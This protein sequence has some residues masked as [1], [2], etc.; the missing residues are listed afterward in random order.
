[1]R[2]T[3]RQLGLPS[4]SPP[5]RPRRR[6]W[7]H[8]DALRWFVNR[9]SRGWTSFARAFSCCGLDSW[10]GAACRYRGPERDRPSYGLCL[11]EHEHRHFGGTSSGWRRVCAGW[12]LCGV[13]HG[14]CAYRARHCVEVGAGGEEGCKEVEHGTG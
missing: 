13:C 6:C 1:M 5:R 2:L 10:S 3:G 8:R 4:C 7:R 12:V 9:R 14:V 11:A